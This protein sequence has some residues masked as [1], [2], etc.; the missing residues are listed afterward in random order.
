MK[1]STSWGKKSGNWNLS[2]IVIIAPGHPPEW[3]YNLFAMVHGK[4]QQDVDQQIQ[5]IS[6][7]LGDYNLGCDVLYSTKI[8]KKTGFRTTARM[9][10]VEQRMEQ[11]PSRRK[12]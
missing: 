10:E 1:P 6:D 7:L 11:L 5:Q 8:L 9:Q 4:S 12:S 2:A 3:M